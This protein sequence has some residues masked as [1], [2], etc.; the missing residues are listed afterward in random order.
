MERDFSV[1]LCKTEQTLK[2]LLHRGMELRQESLRLT[3][4]AGHRGIRV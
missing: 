3:R 2:A 1:P 4:E